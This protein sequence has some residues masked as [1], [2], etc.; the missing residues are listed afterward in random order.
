MDDKEFFSSLFK[1]VTPNVYS[2]H[3]ILTNNY[4]S[5]YD[6]ILN[7][8]YASLKYSNKFTTFNLFLEN[9]FIKMEDKKKI[10]FYFC[11]TQ[12][13]YF[14]FKQFYK[15]HT[16]K[17]IQKSSN[18]FDMFLTPLR[19]HKQKF[20]I[21]LEQ[22]NVLYKFYIFDLTKIIESSLTNC[23]GLICDP[24]EPANPYTNLIF[25]YNDL[26]RIYYF[27][28]NQSIEISHNFKSFFTCNFNIESFFYVNENNLRVTAI[29]KYYKELDELDKY[30]LII[31][32]LYDFKNNWI[33]TRI[34]MRY[35]RDLLV[36]LFDKYLKYYLL[37][38]YSFT[39]LLKNKNK[40]LL[41]K[42]VKKLIRNNYF[43]GKV[44]N[45]TVL[46]NII[47][48][49]PNLT[50]KEIRVTTFRFI[51]LLNDNITEDSIYDYLSKPALNE[52]FYVR[53]DFLI[54]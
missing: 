29:N 26:L 54:E 30:F 51:N 35:P 1:I 32:M 22:D 24:I 43:L 20:I 44:Y 46:D 25:S 36:K 3:E 4:F 39:P 14:F 45:K 2:L 31:H 53:T 10:T 38:K 40:D 18:D 23:N 19:E 41:I 34:D 5:N 12:K 27:L 42:K 17:T 9:K 8:F 37:Y 52:K 33:S 28:I 6:I 21:S 13:L 48:Q 15:N 16:L 7:S 47:S 11:N 50:Y 49:Y